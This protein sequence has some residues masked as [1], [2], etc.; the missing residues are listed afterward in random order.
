MWVQLIDRNPSFLQ[1]W[2]SDKR[3]A[4]MW[5][6]VWTMTKADMNYISGFL[7]TTSSFT[8]VILRELI[9]MTWDKQSQSSISIWATALMWQIWERWC[10]RDRR[11]TQWNS[12]ARGADAQSRLGKLA[13]RPWHVA[14]LL[15][16]HSLHETLAGL[17]QWWRLWQLAYFHPTLLV[18][19][20]QNQWVCWFLLLYLSRGSMFVYP[21]SLFYQSLPTFAFFH[22]QSFLPVWVCFKALLLALFLHSWPQQSDLPYC[23]SI[24]TLVEHQTTHAMSFLKPKL[25]CDS[26]KQLKLSFSHLLYILHY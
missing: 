2:E 15:S 20:H 17:R 13:C 14:P 11:G 19:F 21:L 8:Q 4:L 16:R 7:C 5:L 24:I 26:D 12:G 10:V 25:P 3:R 18:C 22:S 6:A 1:G 23:G 9:G